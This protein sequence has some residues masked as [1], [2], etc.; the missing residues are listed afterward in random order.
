MMADQLFYNGVVYTLDPARPRASA[1]A[2]AGNRIV[3]AGDDDELRELLRPGGRAINL[4][5]QT[6]APGFTDAHLHFLSYGLSLREI[7]LAAVP[8]LAEAQRRVRQRAA[9]TP[10]DHWLIG[11]GWDQSLWTDR[12]FPSRYDLDAVAPDHP[13]FLRRKCGHVGW[14]NSRAL[15]LAGITAATPDPFGGE[16]E[17]DASGEPTGILKENAMG[18]VARL[19]AEPSEA[20][21]L[22][23]VRAALAELHRRGITGV[24]NMEGAAALRAFQTLRDQGEL[25]LRVVQ[26]IPES[27]LDAA[28]QMG[29]R[30]GFGDDRLRIGAVK[31]FAD[32][33]LGAR[34]AL[35]VESYEGE[36]ENRGI[37]VAT[38]GHLKAQVARAARAGIA[39][40]IHAI[41]D[42]ANRNVLDA[43][44]ASRQA[45]LGPQLRH[46]IEHAQLLHP[47]DL[48]RFAALG[49]I[50]SM[51]PI[52][53]TQDMKLADA[54][55]GPERS[56]LAYAWRSLLDTGAV[57]AFGSDAPVEEP[58]VLRGI[59][60]AVTRRR[61]DGSPG[62]D[63]WIGEQRIT[64]A[65]ALYA[66][67]VGA[68]Y[69]VGREAALGRLAPGL[70]AD[71]VV[72]SDDIFTI[73]PM[74]LLETDVIATIVDGVTVF[75]E[76]ALLG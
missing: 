3:A 23:A 49:V 44:E 64:V 25:T 41:G 52:H 56:R 7:D 31:I 12:R 33:A 26:Q 68:A 29:L 75:G 45:G 21:A 18:L 42:Q 17:R 43:I 38:A 8:T 55:W 71:F 54:H 40:H 47:D 5:G 32:G 69:S 4:R 36:P 37:A 65:E 39:V 24:H 61:A 67:T 15:A 16:I 51:Q 59:H 34:T 73:Q 60:A 46:R 53:C 57:L 35:M 63:G 22:A 50:A 20:E 62:P 58:D 9:A 19:L 66:Y 30:S 27:D 1:L 28:I 70:L 11:R 76:D 13:V 74:A 2:V 14:A 6:V 72:L 48:P 10:A